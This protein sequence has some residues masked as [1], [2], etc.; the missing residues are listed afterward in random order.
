MKYCSRCKSEKSEEYFAWRNISKGVLQS[1]CRPCNKD[2]YSELY[3]ANKSRRD[4]I[5]QNNK[6]WRTKRYSY[7]RDRLKSGCVDCGID[8]IRVLEFDHVH[9]T[10]ISGVADMVNQG[11]SFD[12]VKEEIDKCEVR[13]RNCH[14][15]R[16]Y[17]R[18]GWTWACET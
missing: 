15:I 3:K 9:G 11:A 12:R 7:V 1:W 13:C 6:T 4:Q 2:Y 10:K 5:K 18:A 16:T 8:D 14:A 17:K